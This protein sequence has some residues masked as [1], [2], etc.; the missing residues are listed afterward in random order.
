LNHDSHRIIFQV[1]SRIKGVPISLE[2]AKGQRKNNVP[3]LEEGE[4]KSK[5]NELEPC[6]WIFDKHG[7]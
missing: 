3:R 2:I 5:T 6:L 1:A 4:K 7:D